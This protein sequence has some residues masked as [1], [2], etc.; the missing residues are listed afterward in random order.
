[1]YQMGS[2]SVSELK[3]KQERGEDFQLLDVRGPDEWEVANLGGTLIPLQELPHRLSELSADKEVVVLCHHG[4]RSL[5]AAH[6]LVS[7]GF[8]RVLNVKGG[9]DQWSVQ[10]DPTIARY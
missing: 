7:K 1:M 8:R 2:I 6:F 9:I 10:V 4:M 3:Q 5:Q